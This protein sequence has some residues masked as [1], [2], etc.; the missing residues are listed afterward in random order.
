MSSDTIELVIAPRTRDLGDGFTVRRAL[1]DPRRGMIGPFIFFDQMGPATLAPGQGLDVRPHPH[2][3]LATI[4][5]LFEGEILHRDSLGV[6]QPIRPGEVNWMTSGQGIVHSERTA[7]EHRVSGSSIFG[8]QLWVALPKEHEEVAPSF[9]HYDA[10]E[11]PFIEERNLRVHLITGTLFGARSPVKTLSEM[12]YA[13]ALM[14]P[15]SSF[16][17]PAEHEERGIYVARGAVDVD[18]TRYEAGQLLVLAKRNAVTIAASEAARV[19]LLG[20]DPMESPRY[21]WW[22]FVSSSKERIAQ[23]KEDWRAQRFGQVP[24]ETEFI[25]VPEG[26][27]APVMYP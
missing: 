15:G 7:P 4:T 18:G 16:S 1:P 10:S 13:D 11:M 17:L 2:I 9:A 14:Q 20:G 27:T 19:L 23:A 3:G 25:P 22:N 24:R 26:N 12:F 8:I 21:I 5:Y 6:V